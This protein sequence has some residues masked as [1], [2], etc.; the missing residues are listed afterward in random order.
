VLYGSDID[1]VALFCRD[2]VGLTLIKSD[3]D[4]MAALRLPRGGVLLIFDPLA[5]AVAGRPV[6]SHGADGAGHVAFRIEDLA[7]WRAT[8]PIAD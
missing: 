2:I 4:L 7:D 3:P 1:T 8:S 6:P 5:A